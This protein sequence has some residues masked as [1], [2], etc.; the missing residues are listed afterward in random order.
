MGEIDCGSFGV[1]QRWLG[2][3]CLVCLLLCRFVMALINSVSRAVSVPGDLVWNA[4]A[5]ALP[6]PSNVDCCPFRLI[7]RNGGGSGR[8]SCGTGRLGRR[9]SRRCF[10]LN[11]LFL[12]EHDTEYYNQGPH[13]IRAG[14]GE[15]S[16]GKTALKVRRETERRAAMRCNRSSWEPAISYS[17]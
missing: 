12:Q 6:A 3:A 13:S 2:R 8:P 15:V 1:L 4:A 5:V 16:Q 14:R 10:E 7:G 11:R 17:I 9:L